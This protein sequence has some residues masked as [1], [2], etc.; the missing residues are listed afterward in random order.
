MHQRTKQFSV[1][2]DFGAKV[3]FCLILNHQTTLPSLGCVSNDG[4]GVGVGQR[5]GT[6]FC[7]TAVQHRKVEESPKLNAE[8]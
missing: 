1:R 6:R 7:P 8:C 5:P 2:T 4:R 3:S